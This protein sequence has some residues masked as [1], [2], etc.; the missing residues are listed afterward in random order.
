MDSTK[1]ALMIICRKTSAVT[2]IDTGFESEEAMLNALKAID[3]KMFMN[4]ITVPFNYQE[5]DIRF[6][7]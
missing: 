2:Y 5:G 7:F 3:S 6:K 1:W 4:S